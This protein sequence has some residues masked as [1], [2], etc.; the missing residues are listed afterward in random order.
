MTRSTN[1][2]LEYDNSQLS[3]S[4]KRA[5]GKTITSLKMS[6]DTLTLTM[7]DGT[8]VRLCDTGQDCCE[9]RYMTTDDTLA[10][11]EGAEL[12]GAEVASGGSRD[13][14]SECHDIEFLRINTDRGD[15]V[16]ANHNEHNGYY[17]GFSIRARLTGPGAE[18]SDPEPP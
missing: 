11:F 1:D 16:I 13:D 17:G 5:I 7:H 3:K 6:D 2:P 15:L 4:I 8:N 18:E 14:G 10:D 9:H 12:R